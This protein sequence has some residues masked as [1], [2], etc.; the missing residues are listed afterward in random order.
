M[1]KINLGQSII[2]IIVAVGII[3]IIAVTAISTIVQSFT[4]VRLGDNETDATLWDQE[5]IE[6][7][8]SIKNQAWTNLTNGNHGVATGSGVWAF[9]GISNVKGIYTRQIAVSDIYRDTSGNMQTS[10]CANM[11]DRNAKRVVATNNWNSSPTRANSV[12]LETYYTNW[13]KRVVGNWAVPTQESSVNI[14]GNQDP[15]KVQ[16]QG[17]YAYLIRGGGTPNFVI[18]DISAVAP[19]IVGSLTLSSAPQ[20]IYILGRYAFVASNDNAQ[21]FQIIDVCTPSSPSQ[22]GSM[23]L[24]GNADANGVFAAGNYAYIVRSSSAD[25]EFN[26]I[27]VSTPSA[28]ALTGS[29]NLGAIGHEV[30]VV[31]NYAF[32]ATGDNS[33][34]FKVIDISTPSAPTLIGGLNLSGNSDALTVASFDSEVAVGRTGGEF[35]MISVSTPSTP[36]LQGTYS[37]GA[38]INDISLGNANQ[39]AFLATQSNPSEVQIVNITT[40]ISP[41]L[42]G[43]FNYGSNTYGVAYSSYDDKAYVTTASNTAELIVL[44]PS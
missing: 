1:K 12:S 29:L 30:S 36:T 5:G 17:H 35:D 24:T 13:K 39:Y 28:P 27:N 4:I 20:N 14:S 41:T 37:A 31:G 38:T 10:G 3:L 9:S 23:N 26:I 34:E 8:R 40:P 33:Q 11:L 32:L 2:E 18:F 42:L 21:E 25:D 19:T 6:A 15:Q 44:I 16:V 7:V 43:S 22:V